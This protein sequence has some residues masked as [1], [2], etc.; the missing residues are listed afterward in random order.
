MLVDVYGYIQELISVDARLYSED[1]SSRSR[2]ERSMVFLRN[3]KFHSDTTRPLASFLRDMASCLRNTLENE[4][5]SRVE[6]RQVCASHSLGVDSNLQHSQE[7]LLIPWDVLY[8]L[9]DVFELAHSAN[10]DEGVFQVYQTMGR[11][12]CAQARR[13]GNPASDISRELSTKLD[14]FNPSWQLSSG[15]G[16]E[17]LWTAFR[18]ATAK[19]LPQLDSSLL[20]KG[21][22]DRFDA[23]K[24]SSGASVRE[25]ETLQIS[26]VQ[27]HDVINTTS[28]PK[29][30][31][32]DV[33]SP[34][35][36]KKQM[37]MKY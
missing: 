20:V 1:Q 5:L 22:A 6:G 29:S 9:K 19:D 12:L 33:C 10:F 14:A 2:L 31:P 30:G 35:A 36:A 4:V 8:Y 3:G 28:F 17:S 18:P 11:S 13:L 16:M 15:L 32:L 34:F 25:L 7:D 23:A 26:M 27:I 37:L 21:L 24:W